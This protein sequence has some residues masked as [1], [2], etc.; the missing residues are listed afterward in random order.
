MML[1]SPNRRLLLSSALSAAAAGTLVTPL[2]AAMRGKRRKPLGVALVGLGSY[3]S[4]RL[5]PGLALTRYCRLVGIVTGSPHKIP[6]WQAK[7][8]I[9]DRNVYSYDDLER[10]ANNPAIDVVYVV[11]PTSLHAPLTLRAAA[12]GKHVWCEKPM[13]LHADQAQSMIDACARN[14]VRLSIGYRMQHEPNTRRVIAL[15]SERPF[16]AMRKVYA[17]AGYDGYRDTDPAQ[18]PWRLRGQFGGGAMYDM[19]VYPLN[20]ARYTVGTEPLAVSAI[21]STERPA[22]FD[23]VDE[24]MRF[25][26]EFPHEVVVECATSFG[27]NM[28]RLRAECERGWYGLAP[29]QAYDGIH[30]QASDGRVFDAMVRHQQALQ[31]DEDALAILT[32]GPLRAPGEEGLRDI[33]IVDA[34]YR[35]AGAGGQRIVL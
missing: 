15:A 27:R 8:R 29:F 30:G 11:T 25:T 12:A 16:G 18:R 10:I 17:E 31:M 24:H 9:P 14:K 3:A 13:A 5:A 2:W 23:E 34:I 19:G 4:E 6:H 32:G 22:L 20:A 7:Y 33:R 21:R 1:C 35:S 28:N 26:L